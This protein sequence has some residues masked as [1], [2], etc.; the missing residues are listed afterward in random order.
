MLIFFNFSIIIIVF[1]LH[2]F[3]YLL[4][5]YAYLDF[6]KQSNEVNPPIGRVMKLVLQYVGTIILKIDYS[7]K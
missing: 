6:V 1:V 3:R 2:I 7:L 5:T 4:F